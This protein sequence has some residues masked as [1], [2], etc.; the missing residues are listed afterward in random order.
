MCPEFNLGICKVVGI[1]PE[2][3]E[4]ADKNCCYNSRFETCRLYLIEMLMK[5]NEIGSMKLAA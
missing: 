2:N 5:C 1:E 3:V 4:C